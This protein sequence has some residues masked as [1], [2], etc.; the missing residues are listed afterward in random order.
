[1]PTGSPL[2]LLLD[3]QGTIVYEGDLEGVEWWD[4]LAGASA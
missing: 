4:A 2:V 1:M 3:A